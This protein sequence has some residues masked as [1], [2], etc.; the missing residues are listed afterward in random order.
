M[1]IR[2]LEAFNAVMVCR[3]V[4][5]AA[6]MLHVSQPAVTR[7]IG[8]LEESAGFALFDRAHGR[9][10]PTP[11]AFALH[12]EV[13]RSLVGV[14]R[15]ERAASEIRASQRGMLQIASAPALALSFLP[16]AIAAFSELHSG[17]EISLG[18]HASRTVLDMVVAH[19]C[20]V[21]FVILGL[22]TPAAHG[23]LLVSTRM[24][25]AMPARH[26]LAKKKTIV[27]ADLRNEPF[28]SHWRG[29]QS[30]YEIDALFA[31]HGVERKLMVETQTSAAICSFVAAGMGVAIIDPIAALEYRGTDVVFRRFEP[32]LGT[33][34]SVLLPAQRPPSL[35]VRKFVDHVRA[36]VH[37]ELPAAARL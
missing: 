10:Q 35:L 8:D 24:V 1:K 11:E 15:I 14:E 3:T 30:R 32:V 4:T 5:R 28:V 31:S 23:E 25:C 7:L 17:V 2:Q 27:P 12:E 19:R 36:F 37:A 13:Q 20:D 34:F 6:E 18:S 29:L 21:G 16:R 22:S 9:L 26:R 33:D